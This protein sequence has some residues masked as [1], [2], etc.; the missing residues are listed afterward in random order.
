MTAAELVAAKRLIVTCGAGGVGKTTMAAAVALQAALQGRRVAVLTI[1]PARRLANSLGLDALTGELR[2]VSPEHFGA[3]RLAPKGELWAMMLDTKTTGDQMVRRF[4]P[5]AEA[6]EAILKNEW[7][8]FFSTSLA[9]SQEY[10]AVEEVRALVSERG[11][12]LVV[13]DTPPAVN[14]LDFLD[15]PERLVTALDSKAVQLLVKNRNEPDSVGSKLMSAGRGVLLRSLSRLTGGGF[16]DELAN[17]LGLFGSII[18]AMKAAGEELHTL[19]RAEQTTF[20]LVTTP[21]RSN[22]DDAAHFRHELRARNFPFGGFVCNRVHEPYPSVDDAPEALL[23]GF[24]GTPLEATDPAE[25]LDL[26]QRMLQGLRSHNRMADRDREAVARLTRIAGDAP[27]IVPL[28]A[29]D[30]R[31]LAGLDAVGRC[32]LR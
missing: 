25:Q 15:A 11:F 2:Q 19:L 20:L 18:E 7:Y 3:V 4:A 17:F 24:R 22:I 28:F 30:V 5:D 29:R 14:A 26:V 16:L 8:R 23:P 10:M 21:T 12:D 6:A 31:D 1:D 32:L 13:L 27:H 9:G